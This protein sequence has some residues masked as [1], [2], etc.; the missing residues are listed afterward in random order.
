[1]SEHTISPMKRRRTE[2]ASRQV[3]A[4][5]LPAFTQ[6]P[7]T[8]EIFVHLSA[9]A[10]VGIAASH[11]IQYPVV[12]DEPLV[13]LF[14]LRATG[15]PPGSMSDAPGS[16]SLGLRS[17]FLPEDR[18]LGESHDLAEA[19]GIGCV[20]R[21]VL[22]FELPGLRGGILRQLPLGFAK[23]LRESLSPLALAATGLRHSGI[24]HRIYRRHRARIGPKDGAGLPLRL[25]ETFYFWRGARGARNGFAFS[26]PD[27]FVG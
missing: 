16:F 7:M 1:M 27:T 9:E 10:V 24:R 13:K 25:A 4:K 3:P 17:R 2:P 11:G 20:E 23:E 15:S 22:P 19:P 6:P 18:R 21:P 8:L 5:W 12:R 26:T 14:P